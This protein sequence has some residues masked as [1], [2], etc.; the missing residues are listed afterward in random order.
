MDKYIKNLDDSQ[1]REIMLKAVS[2]A[3]KGRGNTA[4][5]PCV[6]ALLTRKGEIVAQSW[7]KQFGGKHAEVRAIE[8]AR[9]LGVNPSSC[10]LWVTLEPCN[11]IGRTPPCTR[12]ILDA[13]IDHVIAGVRD[14]NQQVK[15]GGLDYLRK[16]GIE[17]EEGIA[18][19]EC[20]D[21]I[22]DFLLWQQESRPYVYLKLASTL[23]G[24]IANREGEP[25][26]ISG[27]QSWNRVHELRSRVQAV[28]V[29]GNTFYADD[30]RLTARTSRK[31][32]KQPRAV[33][34]TSRLPDTEKKYNLLGTRPRD[35]MFWTANKKGQEEKEKA[36]SDLGGCVWELEQSANETDF[37]GALQRLYKEQSCYYVLCEG[38]GK[39]AMTLFKQGLVDTFFH[40][41]NPSVLGDEMAVSLFSGSRGT[42]LT[43]ENRLRLLKQENVGEDLWLSLSPYR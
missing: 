25:L 17:V 13:G 40:V 8:Q 11:H 33:V 37:R 43:E 34:V 31:D 42:E 22:S 2:L 24:K 7:H 32:I 30:P 4:P 14:P 20:R 19:Q 10:T 35:V 6:G 21:S 38:G 9:Q 5:N 39:L 12:A 23:D 28:L 18:W 1:K 15:G 16:V 26:A 41:L 36:I 27:D 3:E 29:G